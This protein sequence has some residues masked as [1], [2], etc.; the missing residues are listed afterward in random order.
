MPSA[1]A[2]SIEGPLVVTRGTLEEHLLLTGEVDAAVSAELSVPRTDDWNIAI[3]WMAEDGALVKA[4]ERV[5]E[6]D[7]SA[8][9]DRLAELDLAVV[10][11][12]IELDAQQAEHAVD[13]EEKRF[14]VASQQTAV[15]KAKL[16]AA[17]PPVLLSQREAKEYALELSRAEVAL[18]SAEADLRSLQQAGKHDEQVKKLAHGKALRALQSTEKQLEGLTLGAP[19]DGVVLI[20]QQPWEKRKLQVGDN[21]W[22]GMAVAKLPDLSKMV[23]EATLSDVDDGR[24]QPGMRARCIVDAFPDTPLGGSVVGVSPIAH[25]SAQRSSRRFFAVAVELDQANPEIL[26]PGF[27]VKVEVMTRREDDV[28]I[29]PRAGLDLAASPVRALLDGG[30][31]VEVEV[32]FCNAHGCIIASGLE[33]GDVLRPVQEASS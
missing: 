18:A 11:A 16:D 19:R 13:L 14:A 21:V 9:V 24:V 31:A 29:A 8:V 17:I 6:F 1:V 22:P 28:L 25:E 2:S 3:R 23:I 27:S 20:G 30:E 26:R 7:N 12:E 4:G 15:A 10:E 32:D 33:A 5:V